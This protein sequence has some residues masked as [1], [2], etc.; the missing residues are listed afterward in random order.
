V[1]T[2]AGIVALLVVAGEA[3][4]LAGTC[5]LIVATAMFVAPGELGLARAR[6][7][8]AVVGAIVV[9]VLL[10]AVQTLPL[11]AAA[12]NSARAGELEP[13]YW[14][15]HPL[16]LVEMVA[17]HLF[18][19][20][21]L[22]A[23]GQ[24][25]IGALNEGRE[26]LLY[27]LYLGLGGIVLASISRA[28]GEDRR[29]RW[30]WASVVGVAVVCG[31]GGHTP[32]YPAL[33]HVVPM[34]STFRF[35][36]K[37]LVFAVVGIV[38]L[39]ATGADALRA[40]VRGEHPMTRP[41]V[42]PLM[43][44]AM[45]LLGVLLVVA[46]FLVPAVSLEGWAM[47]AQ[48]VGVEAPDKAASWMLVSS[49]P[50]WTRLLALAGGTLVLLLVTWQRQ[51]LAPVAVYSLCALALL[52][53]LVVNA[54]LNPTIPATELGPPAW[55]GLTRAHPDDRVYVGGYV[56]MPRASKSEPL[57]KLDD[58]THVA[59]PVDVPREQA[60]ARHWAQL[61]LTP[62]PWGIRQ[63]ISYDLPELWAREY[64]EM[65]DVFRRAPRTD[66]FRFLGRTGVRYCLL[67][68]PP[69][70]G[71]VPLTGMAAE[72]GAMALYE[73][74]SPQPRVYVAPAARVE[75]S[76]RR[77]LELML[78]KA[79]DPRT[80]VLLDHQPPVAS[81]LPNAPE[82]TPAAR[83]VADDANELVITATAGPDG[84][85]LTLLDSFD[86]DWTVDVDGTP[87]AQ[88]RA[89]GLF[90]A[91]RLSAGR[92]DVRFT[93]R[94]RAFALGAI[95]TSATGVALLFPLVALP[96]FGRLRRRQRV[97][98]ASPAPYDALHEYR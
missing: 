95:V 7:V 93:Y 55:V 58:V 96:Y 28:D 50:H 59:L 90:R 8:A 36:V 89:N 62:G 31:L 27:S 37:Y 33:E 56:A 64:R 97:D 40:H 42:A 91:V 74:A 38:A 75:P 53:P 48:R 12:R 68:E 85:Y 34:L 77:Q 52:D 78:D 18:G 20:P 25:W 35:P 92:H 14:S 45:V 60:L 49:T 26:P 2:L 11:M 4:T 9:G 17:G 98:T 21:H 76:I 41:V 84:G 66:R 15:A 16:A 57:T 80:H 67:P 87:A 81:G 10:S 5:G 86:P 39:A 72:S 69:F 61:A 6:R 19:Q 70:D 71:A 30:F 54:D 13:L 3:V 94:P 43:L 73:C 88:L 32:V 44:G 1:A 82:G 22:G 29:W 46:A 63:V 47:I 24:P 83:I 23:E 65:L 79:Y 51:R